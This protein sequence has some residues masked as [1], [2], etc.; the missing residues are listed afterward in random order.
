MFVN[1]SKE[2]GIQE[3]KPKTPPYSEK[4]RT[5]Q[6][7]YIQYVNIDYDSCLDN[8]CSCLD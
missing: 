8:M 6:F 1:F 2:F 3:G 4:Y 7:K 5:L